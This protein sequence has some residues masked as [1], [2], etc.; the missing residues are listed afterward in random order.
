MQNPKAS[1]APSGHTATHVS[2]HRREGSKSLAKNVE[3]PVQH[4]SPET[5]SG[6]IVHLVV[7]RGMLQTRRGVQQCCL[8]YPQRFASDTTFPSTDETDEMFIG[9]FKCHSHPNVLPLWVPAR[10]FQKS[11]MLSSRFSDI[12]VTSRVIEQTCAHPWEIPLSGLHASAKKTQQESPK[13]VI[14]RVRG[15]SL[16]S[17]LTP[18]TLKTYPWFRQVE[19][20]KSIAHPSL[21]TMTRRSKKRTELETPPGGNQSNNP[22]LC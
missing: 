5:V 3:T 13:V 1:T 9:C 20:P 10:S 14:L 2:A 8:Q 21:G 22:V 18:Q 19:N 17:T 15:C 7:R 16:H 6:R 12:T 4:E 11:T